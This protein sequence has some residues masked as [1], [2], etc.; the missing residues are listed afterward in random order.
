MGEPKYIQHL[1][2]TLWRR[3]EL[4]EFIVSEMRPCFQRDTYDV[5]CNNCN[6]FSDRLC[7][8]LVGKH[9]P[10]EVLI[11]PDLLLRSRSVRMV[12]PL[13]NYWLRD[14]VVERPP[15]TSTQQGERLKLGHHP[16]LGSLVFVHAGADSPNAPPI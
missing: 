4:H 10:K 12:R 15:R 6:H 1:G 14:F 8:Y 2:F 16:P 13:L 11:Q 7:M 9:C 5:V 3:D